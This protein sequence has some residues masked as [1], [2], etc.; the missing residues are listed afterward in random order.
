MIQEL[1]PNKVGEKFT[2]LQVAIGQKATHAYRM[3]A[4]F[5]FSMD[6]L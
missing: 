6:Q 4:I 3:Q 2:H 1:K 5:H